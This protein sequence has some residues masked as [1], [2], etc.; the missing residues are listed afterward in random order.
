MVFLG[1]KVDVGKGGVVVLK[2]TRVFPVGY[3]TINVF[4]QV[5]EFV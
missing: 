4:V 1:G 3:L 5:A 2:C